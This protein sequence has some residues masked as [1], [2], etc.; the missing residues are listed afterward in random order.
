MVS[1]VIVKSPWTRLTRIRIIESEGAKS[2]EYRLRRLQQVGAGKKGAIRWRCELK[3]GRG[4][5]QLTDRD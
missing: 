2:E 1:Q 5:L 3:Q 4:C